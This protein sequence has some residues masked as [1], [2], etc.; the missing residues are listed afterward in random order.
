M[1]KMENFVDILWTE[2]NGRPPPVEK[3]GSGVL[4]K[5]EARG[6]KALVAGPL[7][8]RFFLRLPLPFTTS[9]SPAWLGNY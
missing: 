6:G 9:S 2:A 1:V 5:S 3:V 4:P 8:K 7:K